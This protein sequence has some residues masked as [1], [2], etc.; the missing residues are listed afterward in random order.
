MDPAIHLGTGS[1]AHAYRWFARL[2]AAGVSRAYEQWALG[3]SDD[4]EVLAL[5]SALPPGKRQPN[6]VFAAARWH[7]A[8]G[9]YSE[10]RRVLVERWS[11]IEST[12]LAR[13]TQTNEAGRCA[14]LVP[15]LAMLPQPLAV[16]EVG[17]SAGLCLLP[18]RYSYRY[19]DA[20]QL[21]PVDGPADVVLACALGPG[22]RAPDRLP[23][24]VWRAGIDLA[25]V[26]VGDEDACSWLEALVWPE[27]DERRTRLRAA[28]G[29]ARRDPPRIIAGDLVSALPD[30]AAAAPRDAT[31]VVVHSAVL[32][33]LDTGSRAAFVDLVSGL[34]GHWLSNEGALVLPQT[35]GF[36]SDRPERGFVVTLD[37]VP[38]AYAAPHGGSLAALPARASTAAPGA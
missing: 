16:I 21:D 36:A 7:G 17:A 35:A 8:A 14:T 13:A 26:D 10:V 34:P 32:A 38:R 24:V 3:V 29:I 12:I 15:F 30:L 20:P 22:I 1:V 28:L 31:L 5:I 4:P 18:D 25:P 11:A 23:E 27:H 33:Y 37:G 2:E 9:S 19:D 6:L